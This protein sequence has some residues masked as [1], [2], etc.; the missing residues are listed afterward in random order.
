MQD[1][2]LDENAKHVIFI[3]YYANYYYLS[4]YSLDDAGNIFKVK[5][6]STAIWYART[7]KHTK[8]DIH[9]VCFSGSSISFP[10][11]EECIAKGEIVLYRTFDIEE[12]LIGRLDYTN[13]NYVGKFAGT[14]KKLET[15]RL[16]NDFLY[17][18]KKY[19]EESGNE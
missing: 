14:L 11:F 17:E 16:T 15:R 8:Q 9:T 6:S 13:V 12:N 5:H 18:L 2:S 4:R 3:D 1:K 10:E 19:I 7:R